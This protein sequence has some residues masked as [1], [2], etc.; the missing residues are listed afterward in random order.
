MLFVDKGLEPVIDFYKA[1]LGRIHVALSAPE[2][3]RVVTWDIA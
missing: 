1:P 3:N 2:E